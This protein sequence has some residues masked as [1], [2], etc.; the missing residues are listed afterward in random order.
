LKSL[1]IKPAL[2][3]K[4]AVGIPRVGTTSPEHWGIVP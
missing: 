4:V 3:G 1:W 2:C